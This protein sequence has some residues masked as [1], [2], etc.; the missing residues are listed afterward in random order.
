MIRSSMS[1]EQFSLPQD[2][3]QCHETGYRYYH[4]M[5]F[6]TNECLKSATEFLC[7]IHI[8]GLVI[9]RVLTMVAQVMEKDSGLRK[10]ESEG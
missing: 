2:D 6:W 10:K 4:H 3:E 1:G 8:R 9:V 5:I 7:T